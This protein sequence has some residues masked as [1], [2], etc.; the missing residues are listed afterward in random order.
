MATQP[1]SLH[2]GP[3]QRR[4][5]RR[6][7]HRR[8]WPRSLP[9][10]RH[11]RPRLLCTTVSIVRGGRTRTNGE[12]TTPIDG[13]STITSRPAIRSSTARSTGVRTRRTNRTPTARPDRARRRPP[14]RCPVGH[15]RES[16]PRARGQSPQV[17]RTTRL[18]TNPPSISRRGR[19]RRSRLGLRARRGFDERGGPLTPTAAR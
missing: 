12:P 18:L 16:Q 6:V 1:A 3:C 11:S 14:G 19:R 5:E 9:L 7:R 2:L 17:S 4:A 10:L 13:R 15:E 8:E